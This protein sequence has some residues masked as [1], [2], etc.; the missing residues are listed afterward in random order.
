MLVKRFV[1]G[2][3]L[4]PSMPEDTISILVL[5]DGR[6]G[7]ELLVDPKTARKLKKDLKTI[8]G[9]KAKG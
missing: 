9:P 3:A 6:S 7:I 1:V 2:V 8:L 4:G 5:Y